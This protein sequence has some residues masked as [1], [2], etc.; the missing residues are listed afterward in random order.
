M[1]KAL[2][3]LINKT[4]GAG[5]KEETKPVK[6]VKKTKKPNAKV[7]ERSFRF[8]ENQVKV[9][10]QLEDKTGIKFSNDVFTKAAIDFMSAEILAVDNKKVKSLLDK[11]KLELFKNS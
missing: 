2:E 10:N 7:F 8:T 4:K 5:L 9:L 1:N 3:D 6:A 11:L